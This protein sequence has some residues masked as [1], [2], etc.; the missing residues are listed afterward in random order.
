MSTFERVKK[1]VVDSAGVD[2]A[3]VTAE[4]KL[5]GDLDLDSLDEVDLA[6]ELEVEFGIEISDEVIE[7]SF[8]VG[9]IV[10]SVDGLL[11]KAA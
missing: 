2:E 3:R 5:Y 9:D 7:S 1:C 4:A 11:A 10:K 6:I 8:T